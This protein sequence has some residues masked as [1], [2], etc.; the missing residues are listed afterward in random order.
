MA[1]RDEPCPYGRGLSPSEGDYL[2]NHWWTERRH[3]G[4]IAHA[5]SISGQRRALSVRMLG[6]GFEGEELVAVVFVL[7]AAGGDFGR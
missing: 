4:L 1:D 5:R 2:I 7:F 6:E 3:F